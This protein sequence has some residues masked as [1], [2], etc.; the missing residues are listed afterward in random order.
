MIIILLSIIAISEI[1]RLY[2]THRSVSKKKHFEQKFDGVQ[3]MIWD[4]EFKKFKTLEIRE[5][6]RREYDNSKSKLFNAEKEITEWPKDKDEG[7]K[8]RI[9]DKVVLLKR[10]IERYESQMKNLDF[11]V[12][13]A[14]PNSQYPDGVQGVDDQIDSLQELKL[15]V[16]DWIK[17]L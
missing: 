11:E 3:K 4:L 5:D 15:M 16:R 7:D 1:T 10:D 14:K 12:E 17:Q 13:G 6:V 8:K 9:E 2:L